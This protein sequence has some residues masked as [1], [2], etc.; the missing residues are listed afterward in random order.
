[1]LTLS[2]DDIGSYIN[3]DH[4]LANIKLS[5]DTS[6]SI[7]T[8]ELI[9]KINTILNSFFS[10]ERYEHYLTSKNYLNLQA[11]HSIVSNQAYSIV[12]IS[13]IIVIFLSIFFKSFTIGLIS[14]IPNLFPILGLFG[15]MGLLKVP[16][17]IGTCIVASV[18]IGIAA[19]DTIHLF[20]RYL[21]A[22]KETNSS[23]VS[24]QITINDE[25]VPIITT[26]L[27]LSFS[28]LVFMNAKFIPL[29][30]FGLL[31]A[32]VLT[33]AVISDLYIGP[34]L[35]SMYTKSLKK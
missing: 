24:S 9:Q 35:L 30:Q 21:R 32:Y 6:S 22:F 2:R 27:S 13:V 4:T 31:S 3:S 8:D 17:N 11:A 18:T 29:M 10:H 12:G 16:L 15:I 33:L 28:F 19:D 26:S 20:S 7:Q 34:I 5:H 1:M 25:I 14:L 23:Y